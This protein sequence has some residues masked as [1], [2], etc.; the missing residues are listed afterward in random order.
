MIRVGFDGRMFDDDDKLAIGGRWRSLEDKYLSKDVIISL[1]L[2]A[3]SIVPT[4]SHALTIGSA[5]GCGR[6]RPDG[7]AHLDLT[8]DDISAMAGG[9]LR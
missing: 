6:R 4:S 1:L 9:R 7:T 5:V 2:L 3:I 8:E